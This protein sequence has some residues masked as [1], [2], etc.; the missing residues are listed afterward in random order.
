MTARLTELLDRHLVTYEA[1]LAA[2]EGI[3]ARPPPPP[4]PPAAGP[5]AALRALFGPAGVSAAVTE[6]AGRG[7]GRGREEAELML[8]MVDWEADPQTLLDIR[9]VDVRI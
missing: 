8:H 2:L 4:P 1:E 5:V 6:A 9:W 3:S 7:G